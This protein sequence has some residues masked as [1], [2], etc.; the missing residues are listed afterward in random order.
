MPPDLLVHEAL[1]AVW[2][3]GQDLE[4]TLRYDGELAAS[5]ANNSRVPEKHAIRQHFHTQLAELWRL[6]RRLNTLPID[7]IPEA[8]RS[9]RFAFDVTRPVP[10]D[11]RFFYRWTQRGIAFIPLAVAL[12]FMRCELAIRVHR[13]EAN[14]YK[15]RLLGSQ[16]D[17]DNQVK[18]LFDALRMPHNQDE[19]PV[20]STHDGPMF[21]L[22]EDDALVTKLTMEAKRILSPRPA[23]KRDIWVS[24]DIDVRATPV[25]PMAGNIEMLFP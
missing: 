15:G 20:A 9:D 25:A 8:I 19:V 23:D 13:Y 16:G 1:E 22:L 10:N 3:G 12:R 4:F 24:V 17:L 6:D 5:T 2:G 21:C 14:D 11:T 7:S 18:T